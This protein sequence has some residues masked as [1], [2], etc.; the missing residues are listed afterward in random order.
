M[1]VNSTFFIWSPLYSCW[2][3][4]G[5]GGGFARHYLFYEPD[6]HDLTLK[7]SDIMTFSLSKKAQ[8]HLNMVRSFYQK[9][10]VSYVNDRPPVLWWGEEIGCVSDGEDGGE[11]L[12][13]SKS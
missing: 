9:W 10:G 6:A 11:L 8:G 13:M 12:L 2:V 3:L 5:G 1:S 7:Y 4:S